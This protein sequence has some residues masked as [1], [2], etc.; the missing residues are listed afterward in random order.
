[1]PVNGKLVV[2]ERLEDPDTQRDEWPVVRAVASG[3]LPSPIDIT[4]EYMRGSST[5]QCALFGSSAGSR[6]AIKPSSKG[7]P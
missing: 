6:H 4:H 7:Q 5:E 2:G 3:R 1:M